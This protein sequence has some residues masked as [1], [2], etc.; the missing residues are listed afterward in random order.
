MN[1]TSDTLKELNACKSHVDLFEKT[2]PNGTTVT[3]ESFN[4][5]R[6]AGLNIFWLIETMP[7]LLAKN[8]SVFFG[9]PEWAYNCAGYID[10]QPRDDT[11][12]AACKDPQWAYRYAANIDKQPHS[13]T[14]AA[15]CLDPRSARL[16]ALYVDRKT[17]WRH[18]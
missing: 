3:S 15:A 10:K 2:F 6:N 7:A 1:I 5:A 9:N 13:D 17:T 11:R 4:I 16:Y 18:L 8:R 14:R 12:T